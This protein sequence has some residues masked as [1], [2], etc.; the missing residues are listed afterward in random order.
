MFTVT[1]PPVHSAF[2]VPKK[3]PGSDPT[4]R[5]AAVIV[6]SYAFPWVALREAGHFCPVHASGAGLCDI[7]RPPVEA[8][9]PAA[10]DAVGERQ[11]E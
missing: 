7:Y 3:A 8:V 10:L 11:N 4:I 2:V 6:I 5:V 9:L 1:V